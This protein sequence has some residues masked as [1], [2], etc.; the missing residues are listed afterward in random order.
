MFGSRWRKISRDVWTRKG[1]TAM[2]SIA[3]FVGVLGVVTLWSSGDL[4][5]SQLDKDLKEDQLPMQQAFVSAPGGVQLDNAEALR[6]LE[7]FPGVTRVEGRAVR[8]LLWKLPGDTEYEDGSILAA[9]DPF[10]EIELQPLRITGE[11]R[12]PV[13]G[14]HEIAVEK[15]MADK[16]GLTVGDQILLRI[17]GGNPEGDAW[18]ISGI[19]F[20]P[21]ASFSGA[22]QTVPSDAS[23]FATFEDAQVIGGF[24]G[25]SVFYVRYTD[26]PT[27]QGQADA[28]YASIAQ[29][30]PYV[31]VFNFV[32]DPS[33]NYF[34]TQAGEI[35]G[36]ITTLGVLAM[37]VSG[38][39][40]VNVINSIVGEQRRQIGVMKSLGATRWDNFVIYVGVALT[41]GVIGTIPGVAIGSYAG[42]VMAQALDESLFTFID[43]FTV[44]WAAIL[45][46]AVMGLVIPLIAALIPVFLGTRVTIL[47]ALTDVGISGS[48]GTSI[49]ARA[50]H[51]LPL[52]T[53]TRQAITNVTR[54]KGR[55]ALTWLTLTLAVAAFMG[56]FGVFASINS[57]IGDVFEAFGFDIAV[58]P[59]ERQDFEQARALVSEEVDGV[60][61][62][63]P[64][65]SVAVELEGYVEPDFGTSQL[66]MIGFDPATD[67]LDLDIQAGTAWE[68]DPTREGIVLSRGVA[69]D[70][71]KTAGD[72]VVLVAQGQS[73]EIEIIGIA[74]FPFDQGF[75]RWQTL[76][77]L[78]GSTDSAGQP[79]PTSMFVQITESDPSVDQVDVIIDDIDQ[80]L[81]SNGIAAS[82]VN[83]VEAAEEIADL[84]A[85]FGLTFESAAIVM[86]VVGAIGLLSTLSLSVFERLREIGVMRSIGASSFTVASQFLTEGMLV[87]ISAWIIAVPLSFLV[88]EGLI[89]SLGL[90]EFIEGVGYESIALVI[91]LIG[92]I[93]I[94]ALAS[95][96]PSLS[97][98]RRTVS[99][100]LRYQ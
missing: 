41:Y 52:P 81:L 99:A 73:T 4:L 46:G 19:V 53:N 29:E 9:W 68:D 82:Q 2:V 84:I 58:V 78:V 24:A 74:S 94:T 7:A 72:T 36:F 27:A 79:I 60:R 71:G 17:P 49:L 42:F 10:E 48:Y 21:Y 50:I 77:R 1:R 5:V 97:A 83:Q 31:P 59:N 70:L 34:I 30:T 38:L 12:Y 75:M 14:Q 66:Q 62:V 43:G 33:Q 28:F 23:V 40:V 88:A 51:A 32:D 39:L 87:G 11:G 15:R 54:K 26:F 92:I 47:E 100:I 93:L 63:H 85:T 22:G 16:Y 8:P 56:I 61:A 64:G 67:S 55:L 57:K 20:T 37:V 98:A 95:L 96:G 6:R 91:G 69:N 86:A 3:I 25:F 45:I 90:D 76:A 35:T 44:S 89:S 13:T 80:V 18:T 65:V